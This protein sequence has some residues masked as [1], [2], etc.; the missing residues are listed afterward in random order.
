MGEK[1]GFK[2]L[3]L[4]LC[5][6]VYIRLLTFSESYVIGKLILFYIVVGVLKVILIFI[7]NEPITYGSPIAGLPYQFSLTCC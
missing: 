3:R 7:F 6:F 2:K 1:P 5:H 4:S